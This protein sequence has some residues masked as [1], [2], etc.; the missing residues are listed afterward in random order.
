MSI[1][2]DMKD[3]AIMSNRLRYLIK[4]SYHRNTSTFAKLCTILSLNAS[5]S[6]LIIKQ[7]DR[8]LL[9]LLLNK[10]RC[11]KDG[12][13]MPQLMDFCQCFRC[14]ISLPYKEGPPDRYGVVSS[15][16]WALFL[17]EYEKLAWQ[18]ARSA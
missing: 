18:W 4:V 7:H 9:D 8:L 11:Q 2:M 10:S 14:T 6:L 15:K 3:N 17:E 13:I 16:C 12:D 1:Y 5:N